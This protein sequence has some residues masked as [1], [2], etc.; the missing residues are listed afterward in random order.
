MLRFV[1]VCIDSA[2]PPALATFW[3]HAL[4]WHRVDED[5]ESVALR[6]PESTGGG[7]AMPDLLL[8]RVDDPRTVKNRVHLDFRPDDQAREVARL[9][10]LGARRVDIGQ[11]DEVT[12]VV[13]ADPE[14]NEFCVLRADAAATTS[15]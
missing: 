2:D 5:E 6:A 10:E 11:G 3:E 14:G 4:G 15:S 13:L 7:E 1:C 8:L 9:I 12:W